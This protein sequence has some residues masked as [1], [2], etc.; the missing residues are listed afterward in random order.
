M[1][2]VRFAPSPTGFLHIGGARTALFNYMYARAQGGRFVLRIED[3]DLERSKQE[4]FDEILDSMKWL[5]LEWDEIYKQSERFDVYREHAQKLVE[6]GAAYEENGAII[7][8]MPKQEVRFFD[9]I[10]GEVVFDTANFIR[11]DDDGNNVVD[12][13]GEL[14][15]KDEVLIK[16]DGS[17][18]YSFC[19]VVDDALME[20]SHIIRGEDHI[21]NTPK[22]I[23]M[24][25]ALGFKVPKFAHLPMILDEQGGKMSKR[26]GAVAVTDYREKGFLPEA[27][28]NYLMLLGWSP[29]G[30]LELLTLKSAI[31]KF[32]VKKINKSAAAF[33]MDKLRWVN[34]QYIKQK[35]VGEITDFVVPF[36]QKNSLLDEDYDRKKIEAIVKLYKSRM[37]DIQ[38]FLDRTRY[39]FEKDFV[40]TEEVMKESLSGENIKCFNELADCLNGIDD[41]THQQAEA[42]FRNFVDEKKVKM[43]D[44]V[45]PVRIAL[46][47]SDVG[48]GLFETMEV[49]G[50]EKTV[51]RLKAISSDR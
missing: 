6:S 33:S 29:G 18:A 21:P 2:K 30:D 27:L 50:K 7:F 47:A 25:L 5:G 12:E 28:V 39:L 38:E 49:L 37:T 4:Y 24:Y 34:A 44:L 43:A 35:D 13:N 20:I 17:P 48:P 22:Q 36:L 51:R 46:T 40:I 11:R 31:K 32:S 8:K 23:L 14:V 10:R 15:L 19:C 16:A 3:T 1:I 41:F 42:A 9:I 45:H 26:T